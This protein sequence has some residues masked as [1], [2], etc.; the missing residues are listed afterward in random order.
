MSKTIIKLIEY[1]YRGKVERWSPSKRSYVWHNG[2]SQNGESGGVLYPWM[3]V[4][5]CQADAKAQ[6]GRATFVRVSVHHA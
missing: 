2:Y 3:T 5:E 4:R 6:G 1:I